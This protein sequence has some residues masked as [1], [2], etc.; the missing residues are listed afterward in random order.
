M[1]TLDR[2]ALS[3]AKAILNGS[4]AI[5]WNKVEEHWEDEK[6]MVRVRV[7]VYSGMFMNNPGDLVAL[8]RRVKG[9]I[10]R[11]YHVEFITRMVI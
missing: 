4:D 1:D 11:G 9:A 7:K 3:Q 10:P 6:P 5:S 8:I 2:N